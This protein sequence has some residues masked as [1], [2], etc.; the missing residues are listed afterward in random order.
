MAY[1]GNVDVETGV[2][3]DVDIIA[4]VFDDIHRC[5]NTNCWGFLLNLS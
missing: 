2:V 4:V 1:F 3:V 5:F